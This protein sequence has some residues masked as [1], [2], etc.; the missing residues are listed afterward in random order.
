MITLYMRVNE[1]LQAQ[2]DLVILR[3]AIQL[4]GENH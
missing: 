4:D 2:V 1:G 3:D